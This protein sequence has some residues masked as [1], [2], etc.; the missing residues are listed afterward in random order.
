MALKPSERSLEEIRKDIDSGVQA[1]IEAQR[2]NDLRAM[3]KAEDAVKEAEKEYADEAQ[4]QAFSVLK[5]AENPMVEAARQRV[6][7]VLGH[8]PLKENGIQTGFEVVPKEKQID[9]LALS[10]FCEKDTTWGYKVEKFNQLL[11]MRACKE[12]GFTDAQIAEVAKTFYMRDLARAEKLGG[13]PTSNNQI[14]KMLQTIIDSFMMVPGEDGQNIYKANSHD[15]AYL[16]M[17]YTRQDK[18]ALTVKVSK[19]RAVFGLLLDVCHRIVTGKMYDVSYKKQ[20]GAS[21]DSEPKM[22]LA[23]EHKADE[24]ETD[25]KPEEAMVQPTTKKGGSKKVGAKKAA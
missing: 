16:L 5:T 21:E 9:L 3:T 23:P 22:V 19:N 20:K 11:T 17:C 7:G 10:A 12:L 4:W 2:A 24:P 8:R 13:T 14:V 6:F 1:M 18:K 15:A 25:V